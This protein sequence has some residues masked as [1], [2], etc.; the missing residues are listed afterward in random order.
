MKFCAL[1]L[2]H[3]VSGLLPGL[4]KTPCISSSSSEELLLL[5]DLD[6]SDGGA[7]GLDVAPW[8]QLE[9]GTWLGE[10]RVRDRLS[11][12]NFLASSAP[13]AWVPLCR[14]LDQLLSVSWDVDCRI[15]VILHGAGVG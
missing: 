5:V 13:G 9:S 11:K 4:A 6:R 15:S 14:G 8:L 1:L 3:T 7:L 12:G 2:L 10:V